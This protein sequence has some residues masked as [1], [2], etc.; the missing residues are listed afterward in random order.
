MK[1]FVAKDKKF[2]GITMTRESELL[3]I[4]LSVSTRLSDLN[5]RM[6]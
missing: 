6:L 4:V 2:T 5:I 1:V 3:K